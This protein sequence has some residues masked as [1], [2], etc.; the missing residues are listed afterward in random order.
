MLILLFLSAWKL[1]T[2][3]S[4]RHSDEYLAWSLE[5]RAPVGDEHVVEHQHLHA[6]GED[7]LGLF[8]AMSQMS[9]DFRLYGGAVAVISLV[10]ES[11]FAELR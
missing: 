8:V 9:Q 2:F 1:V 11:V 4:I 6:A 5:R 10:W 3:E 7:E